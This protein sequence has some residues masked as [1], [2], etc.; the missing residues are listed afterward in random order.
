MPIDHVKIT[1]KPRFA[2]LALLLSLAACTS[3]TEAQSSCSNTNADYSHMWGCIKARVSA[4]K[5]GMM[6]NE[7]GLRYM[8]T[9]D[10]IDEKYQARQITNA[11]AKLLLAR[12]LASDNAD[13][14][15]E[16]AV[17]RQALGAAL[18]GMGN[19]MQQPAR[20]SVSCS[21]YRTGNTVQTRC[22]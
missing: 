3:L 8:A 18:Q 9:G 4:G 17:G 19:S 22:Y 20:R 15:R 12:E 5:A 13:F 1:A 16:N 10:A 11:E 14:N 21:S 7:M 6:D 2:A